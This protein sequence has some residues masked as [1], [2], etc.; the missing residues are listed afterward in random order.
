MVKPLCARR[1]QK[2]GFF[3]R[4][5][6]LG[7]RIKRPKGGMLTSQKQSAVCVRQKIPPPRPKKRS[8]RI[9]SYRPRPINYQ[10]SDHLSSP[11][12]DGG[13]AI[14]FS[15][16]RY[17]VSMTPPISTDAPQFFFNKQPFF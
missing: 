13:A 1:F 14:F 17:H 2:G 4:G 16:T 10:P 6:F 3:P 11:H 8:L 12:T 15:H 9:N 7:A 5:E